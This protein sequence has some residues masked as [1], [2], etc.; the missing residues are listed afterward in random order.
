M[1]HGVRGQGHTHTCPTQLPRRPEEL[2][3]KYILQ[4]PKR[5]QC[6]QV[7]YFILHGF[8]APFRFQMAEGRK[9]HHREMRRDPLSFAMPQTTSGCLTLSSL[10]PKT[11]SHT[12]PRGCRCSPPLAERRR[13]DEDSPAST[14]PLTAWFLPTLKIYL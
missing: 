14:V 12:F 7:M 10:I 9:R 13:R 5:R 3:P 8:N 2:K 1:E 6:T 4:H 11:K